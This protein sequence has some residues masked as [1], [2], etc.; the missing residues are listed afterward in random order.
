LATS[1][2]EWALASARPASRWFLA[3]WT[4]TPDMSA[5]A[6]ARA[7]NM[8]MKIRERTS[9]APF[10]LAWMTDLARFIFSPVEK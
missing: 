8:T 7:E 1:S 6:T 2:P 10:L 9:T 3:I 4:L 5:I